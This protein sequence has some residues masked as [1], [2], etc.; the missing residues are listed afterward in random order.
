[1]GKTRKLTTIVVTMQ[2][3]WQETM[4]KVHKSKKQ[5]QRKPKHKN[6]GYEKEND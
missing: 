2:E 5:Y 3:I 4:P 1:M 6:R